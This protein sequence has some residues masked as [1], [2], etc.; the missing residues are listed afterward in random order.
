M[1][2]TPS[3]REIDYQLILRDIS[4]NLMQL[5]QPKRLLRMVTRFVD[6]EIKL[7]HVSILI[8][9]ENKKHFTFLHSRGHKRI[10]IGFLKIEM[11]HPFIRWFSQ[12]IRKSR[13][14]NH[15][16]CREEIDRSHQGKRKPKKM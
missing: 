1:S 11:K 5:K 4:M 13:P 14:Q 12:A 15:Y 10:P 7:S 6:R 8:F 2:Q 9:E 16:L 3:P